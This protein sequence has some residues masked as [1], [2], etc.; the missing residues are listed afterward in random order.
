M[1]KK[2]ILFP[3]VSSV[4]FTTVI[5]S[6]C[7]AAQDTV[8]IPSEISPAK[9][10]NLDQAKP[11]EIV[12]LKDGDTYDITAQYVNKEINGKNYKML[13]YNGS[14][15]GPTLKVP[16]GAQITVNFKNNTEIATSLHSHGIRLDSK[17]DGV[18]NVDQPAIDQG[19]SFSYTIKFPDAGMFWYHPHLNEPFTQSMG[20]YGNYWV[21]PKDNEILAQTTTYWSP[22]NEEVPLMLNDLLIQNGEID[23]FNSKSSDHALMGKFG[24]TMFVN[25]DTNYQRTFQQ[26]EVVRFYMTNASN[27]RVYNLSIPNIKMKLVGGDNGKYERETWEDHIILA[28][29]ERAII[30]IMF[31]KTGTF[32]LENINPQKTY[33]LATFTVSDQKAPLD[34]SNEF[35]TLRENKDV[36]ADID[37]FRPYFNKQ[38]E[39]SINLTV[40]ISGMGNMGG[41][42]M[43]P[44]G[45]MMMNGQ[46]MSSTSSQ[47]STEN[48][49]IEWEDT[50]A[51]MNSMSTT[52]NVKWKIVDDQTKKEDMM[53]DDWKF[54]VGDKVK[55]KIF[56]DPK[57]AHAMQHPIHLHG[58]R[59]LVLSTNGAKNT[60][61]VW[62][63]TVLVPKGDT[64]EILVNISNPGQ[65]M[66]HCHISEHLASGMMLPFTVSD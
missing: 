64:V 26:G 11:S 29:S 3:F 65:W 14:I 53:I 10:E 58:Q 20:L 8:Q 22:V 6:G 1:Q 36:I 55:I 28:P 46:G 24:N 31:D 17:Y 18:V 41:G 40:D 16:Q 34:F 38:P 66:A 15:P 5:I 27:T 52:D 50:M 35:A 19:K 12:E 39:K 45:N 51:M 61:M 59:F 30:E 63:D 62:K 4:L 60:N 57:T 2:K 21:V 13:A 43:M 44:D 9:T 49:K 42:H 37:N 25:G 54:K 23:P 56:N 32:T 48:D 7:S 47:N 33:K